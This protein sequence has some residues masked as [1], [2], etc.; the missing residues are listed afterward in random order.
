MINAVMCPSL[1]SR[2][3]GRPTGIVPSSCKSSRVVGGKGREVGGP[4]HPSGVLPQ[5]WGGN[6]PN[7]TVTCMALKATAND[8]RH[9]AL[10]HDEFRGHRSGGISNNN[11]GIRLVYLLFGL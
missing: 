3:I 5:N 1:N 9:L 4:D 2:D 8:R 10:Y 7:R 11:N 6:Q